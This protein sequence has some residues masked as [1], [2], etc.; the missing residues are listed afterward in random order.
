MFC[1]SCG[2]P[3][4]E[5]ATSCRICREPLT[6]QSPSKTTGT[7]PRN[8]GIGK[9]RW[10]WL[11]V[12]AALLA[13][14]GFAVHYYR[15]SQEFEV[16]GQLLYKS[17]SHV[18]TVGGARIQVYE[19]KGKSFPPK[20]RYSLLLMRQFELNIMGPESYDSKWDAE[21]A[22]LNLEPLA[23][24]DWTW[25]ESQR[26]RNCMWAGQVFTESLRHRAVVATTSTDLNGR[27]WLRLRRGKYFITAENEVPNY[28]RSGHNPFDSSYTED[29]TAGHAF[30]DIPV[31]VTGNVKVVS[32]DPACSPGP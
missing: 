7:T 30:W 29:A 31:A 15:A 6:Q 23:K 1:S 17:E 12:I 18:R 16:T 32:A 9:A 22:P 24:M 3:N 2:T 5:G 13:A 11:P 27:F 19:D 20:N 8:W 21:L 4:E 10:L 28:W 14:T 25:W 26:L